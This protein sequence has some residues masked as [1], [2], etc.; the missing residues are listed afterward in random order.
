MTAAPLDTAALVRE[1]Q[2][3]VCCGSGGVGKTTSAAALGLLGA[4]AGRRVLVMT[5]DPARRLAQAMG[6]DSLGHDPQPVP[7]SEASGSLAAM[8]LDTK[9]TFDRLVESNAPSAEVRDAIFANHYYQQLS[10]ALGGSRELVAMERVLEAVQSGD[11]DL[12]IVDTPPSQHALDFLDAPK[13]LLE[14]I[15]GS[16]TSMLLRPYGVVARAQFDFFRQSSATALKFLERLS[17]VEVLAD[18]SEFLLAFSGLFEGFKERSHRVMALM[19]EPG[20]AFL[21]ICAP[22]PASIE[23]VRRFAGR[24]QSETL[25]IAGVVANRVH[26]PLADAPVPP[27]DGV[28]DA[29]V[30]GQ[31]LTERVAAAFADRQRL[32]EADGRLLARLQSTAL[33]LRKVPHFNRDLHD[34]GDLAA[35]ARVLVDQP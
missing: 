17:G 14:L 11:Y 18:L 27:L 7:L 5:I 35:F 25:D 15:D 24:L 29:G 4:Q 32:G 28:T 23:Q 9:R 22:D 26:A 12:L 1:R 34:L 10:S 31:P 13:R 21:L 30:N 16:F 33:P 20:T 19:N 2:I 8:M 3:I 6:L